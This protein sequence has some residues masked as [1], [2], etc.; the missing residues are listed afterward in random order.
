M[1]VVPFTCSKGIHVSVTSLVCVVC[2][3]ELVVDL[4]C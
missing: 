4:I 2:L 3:E 1:G